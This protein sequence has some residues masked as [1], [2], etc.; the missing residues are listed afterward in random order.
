MNNENEIT[1]DTPY[2]QLIAA[3][4]GSQRVTSK[5][6]GNGRFIIG[7]NDN[8]DVVI[9]HP[10]VMAVH[11]VLEIFSKSLKIYDLSGT[12]SL[13]I[14][15]K[16]KSFSDLKI[17]DL[18][19]LAGVE[20]IFDYYYSPP[21]S[22]TIS[23]INSE[24]EDQMEFA[25]PSTRHLVN[26][27]IADKIIEEKIEKVEKVEKVEKREFPKVVNPEQIVV[28]KVIE[29][30]IHKKVDSKP[31]KINDVKISKPAP[32]DFKIKNVEKIK[33]PD[34]E[35]DKW[36]APYLIY[37]FDSK[38]NFDDSAILF[39]DK[40]NIF[41]IFN[42]NVD[43]E[44]VE[45][46]IMYK[47]LIISVDY[48]V[49]QSGKYQLC[50]MSK[51]VSDLEYHYYNPSE[52][53]DFI[54]CKDGKFFVYKLI[55]HELKVFSNSESKKYQDIFLIEK[56]DIIQFSKG[57]TT[58]LIRHVQALPVVSSPPI[59]SRDKMMFWIFSFSLLIMTMMATFFSFIEVKKEEIDLNKT[60]ERIARVLLH[61]DKKPEIKPK[62]A[63]KTQMKIQDEKK[64]QEVKLETDN[65]K[66]DK[67]L[68][69]NDKIK[70][71][72]VE[73][74]KGAPKIEESPNNSK[75]KK[76]AKLNKDPNSKSPNPKG[77]GAIDVYKNNKFASTVSSLLSKGGNVSAQNVESS[78]SSLKAE[79]AGGIKSSSGVSASRFSDRV[80]DISGTAD[81]VKD[82]SSGTKGLVKGKQ[83]Y[84]A[85]I[86]AET[87]VVGLMDPDVILRILREHLPQ[88]RYCY[89]REIDSRKENVQGLVKLAFSIGSSGNVT[90]A[91]V[92]NGSA[93]PMNIKS[94][95]IN[96][97]WGIQFPKL[98]SEG[99]VDV[100]QPFNFYAK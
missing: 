22:P 73:V 84:T 71:P 32:P 41:P 19:T 6:L 64:D 44:A 48:L 72:D 78:G 60:P 90:K 13:L 35:S 3:S 43:R 100:I 68:S 51:S 31:D 70:K 54:E 23:V 97:L 74:R 57:D 9:D 37:P 52:K 7:S 80:G 34:L 94:C 46:M 24:N 76:S 79:K 88:F 36:K 21:S 40:E 5:P 67:K 10:N 86:P 59:L 53:N 42:Y 25:P 85:S 14:N 99:V 92:V 83:F 49:G 28:E 82:F 30:N 4:P 58:I 87:V 16:V 55:D 77:V 63:Q 17:K 27:V 56:Q 18:V 65:P 38:Y 69:E 33:K 95:V 47:K 11:C 96:V 1:R 20:L 93:L 39:E 15:Q 91:G 62:M 66:I 12:N 89:Q 75:T 61:K 29:K 2:Y 8:C 50:G 45:V 98:R 26:R 81:G